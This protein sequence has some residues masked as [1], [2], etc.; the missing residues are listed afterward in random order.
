[1]KVYF[2]IGR[3][4]IVKA[5]QEGFGLIVELGG[6]GAGGGVGLKAGFNV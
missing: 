1:M 2:G 5:G 3:Y 4:S 6:V